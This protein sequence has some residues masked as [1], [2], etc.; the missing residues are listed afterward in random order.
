MKTPSST[1]LKVHLPTPQ[2]GDAKKESRKQ[3][4]LRTTAL[5]QEGNEDKRGGLQRQASVSTERDA[6][7]DSTRSSR[8]GAFE[9]SKEDS[10]GLSSRYSRRSEVRG[11]TQKTGGKPARAQAAKPKT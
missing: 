1:S 2:Q 5:S 6:K 9:G 10:L 11:D 4:C 8:G 7:L 3:E